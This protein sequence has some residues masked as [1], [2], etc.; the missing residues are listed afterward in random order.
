MLLPL[1][2]EWVREGARERRR[3]SERRVQEKHS[4]VL[5]IKLLYT[6]SPF[7][8]FGIQPLMVSN[9][10]VLGVVL[11]LL[12]KHSDTTQWSRPKIADMK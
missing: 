7:S 4:G 11:G 3:E 2:I 5:K 8:T 12:Q 6:N 9:S 1:R 10:V